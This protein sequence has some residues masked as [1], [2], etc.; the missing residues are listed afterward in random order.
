MRVYP[1]DPENKETYLEAGE[2]VIWR[3]LGLDRF[4]PAGYEDVP[5]RVYRGVAAVSR[6][7]AF[8]WIVPD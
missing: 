3:W 8:P 1:D 2:L 7:H 6:V 5:T 4:F